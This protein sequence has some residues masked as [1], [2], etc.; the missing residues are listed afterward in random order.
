MQEWETKDWGNF[1]FS[2]NWESIAIIES[3]NRLLVHFFIFSKLKAWL[4][5][6]L[7]KKIHQTEDSGAV[8]D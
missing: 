3:K 5:I 2:K 6:A 4:R 7:V 8:S 1:V